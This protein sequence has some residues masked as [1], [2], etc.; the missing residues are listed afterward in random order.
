MNFKKIEVST[1]DDCYCCE[2]T[3][4][5]FIAS[6]LEKH[7]DKPNLLY[8]D[9]RQWIEDGFARFSDVLLSRLIELEGESAR[10]V[11]ARE[12]M[13]L[14]IDKTIAQSRGEKPCN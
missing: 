6:D 14:Q 1:E 8:R 7:R 4:P 2:M 12:A 5:D 3:M 13:K 9:L 10:V 11:H